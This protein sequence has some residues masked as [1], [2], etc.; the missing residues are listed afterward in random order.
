MQ[1]LRHTPQSAHRARAIVNA[2][3]RGHVAHTIVNNLRHTLPR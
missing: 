2:A 1:R 3:P